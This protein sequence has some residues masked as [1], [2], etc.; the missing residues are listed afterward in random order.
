M[1]DLESAGN[2]AECA[3]ALD[4]MTSGCRPCCAGQATYDLIIVV[5]AYD[6]SQL[7]YT[8]TDLFID[9]RLLR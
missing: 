7:L 3:R 5:D 4:N 9:Q 8:G 1:A 6:R 2:R